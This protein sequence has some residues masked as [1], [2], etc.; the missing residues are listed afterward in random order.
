MR[1]QTCVLFSATVLAWG[2]GGSKS[3]TPF[4]A[5]TFTV[6][7]SPSNATRVNNV[8]ADGSVIAGQTTNPRA[9]IYWIDDVQQALLSS[10][11]AIVFLGGFVSPDG[12]KVA[13]SSGGKP[14]VHTLGGSTD[15]YPV[16][17]GFQRAVALGLG[18]S[19]LL[20]EAF[21][22]IGTQQSYVVK[23]GTIH[24]LPALNANSVTQASRIADSDATVVGTSDGKP[25]R[26]INLSNP[27]V[28]A[29]VDSPGVARG[30]SANGQVV[31]GDYWNGS[32][33]VAF[34][35]TP[36]GG[37]VDLGQLPGKVSMQATAVSA[38]GTVVVG[39]G[40]DDQTLSTSEP[41]VWTAKSGIRSIS[42]LPSFTS[43]PFQGL[44][45]LTVS[46]IS[47]DGRV[48]VGSAKTSGGVSKQ[49]GWVVRLGSL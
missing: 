13:S 20:A 37:A 44:E 42:S 16:P 14:I 10:D 23:D 24:L 19:A 5:S 18:S 3:D 15:A 6:L 25:V 12:Q 30:V 40:Y 26:W 17:D 47:A 8:S 22:G 49:V 43:P 2:C 21:Q 28:E 32:R 45:E 31:V 34:R 4:K 9:A 39:N 7:D 1:L 35:W 46:D 29:V 48:V 27:T 38:D 11:D 33:S 41:F 36:Q